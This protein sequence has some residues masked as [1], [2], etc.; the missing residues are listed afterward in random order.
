MSH[1]AFTQ[2]SR[3]IIILK[4]KWR[5][6][7]AANEISDQVQGRGRKQVIDKGRSI[8]DVAKRPPRTLPSSPTEVRVIQAHRCEF[9]LTIMCEA[10]NARAPEE[11]HPARFYRQA[12]NRPPPRSNQKVQT[13]L[14]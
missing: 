14:P 10:L 8:L 13:L 11:A 2:I 4:L 12:T 7:D 5:N 1:L 3:Q 6:A 9:R